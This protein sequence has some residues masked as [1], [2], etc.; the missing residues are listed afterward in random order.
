MYLYLMLES[1]Q[2]LKDNKRRSFPQFNPQ[3]IM[4]SYFEHA[5]D[6]MIACMTLL[7]EL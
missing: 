3:K 1:S 6:E 5:L 2:H 7:E 4:F